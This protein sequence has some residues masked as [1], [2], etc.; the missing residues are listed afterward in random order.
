[1]NFDNVKTFLKDELLETKLNFIMSV[2]VDIEPFLAKYQTDLPMLPFMRTDLFI[3]FKTLMNRIIKRDVM[4]E[5][6]KN[7]LNI[8]N[9][10]L[11]KK[12]IFCPTDK[13][14]IGFGASSLLKKS[15][16]KEL[17]KL[18]FKTEYRKFI[19]VIIKKLKE[20]SPLSSKLLRGSSCLLPKVMLL[21][22]T[23]MT[24]VD[25]ALSYLVEKNRM[26]EIDADR[27]KNEYRQIISSRIVQKK[28]EKI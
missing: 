1:M 25:A 22:T 17:D 9:I 23:A 12:D 3:L 27:V 6:V 18:K 7:V 8:M 14:D 20:K 16:V 26:N 5:N 11:S 28:I 21:E 4:K 15:K 24:R 2:I 13:V 10:D 19:L